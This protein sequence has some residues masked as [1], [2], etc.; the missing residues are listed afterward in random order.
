MHLVHSPSWARRLLYRLLPNRRLPESII[1]DDSFKVP[2]RSGAMLSYM[3]PE[4]I[5]AII[6]RNEDDS[7]SLAA[8]SLTCRAWAPISQSY[9]LRAV[10]L[11]SEMANALDGFFLVLDTNSHIKGYVRSLCV[12]WSDISS[13]GE[14]YTIISR[15]YDRLLNVQTVRIQSLGV[16]PGNL[17]PLLASTFPALQ[18]LE[19]YGP[20]NQPVA[21]F[22]D[23]ISANTTLKRVSLGKYYSRTSWSRRPSLAYCF[24]GHLDCL[25]R[26]LT[27][28]KAADVLSIPITLI[29]FG[30]YDNLTSTLSVFGDSLDLVW[31]SADLVDGK[32]GRNLPTEDVND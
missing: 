7:K 8:C 1:T 4:M 15:L 23:I 31:L 10:R 5:F 2:A 20:C 22:V 16:L 12:S 3:P 11:R 14:I 18:I 17:G 25:A 21:T 32:T 9:L 30:A 28:V 29:R 19:L 6:S 24:S 27:L 13:S 26:M